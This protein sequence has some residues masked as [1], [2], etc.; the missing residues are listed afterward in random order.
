[1]LLLP[2]SD[3]AKVT[4]KATLPPPG[5]PPDESVVLRSLP[6]LKSP[7]FWFVDVFRDDI[8]IGRRWAANRW[9]CTVSFTE[10]IEVNWPIRFRFKAQRGLT[11]Y[12]FRRPPP[13]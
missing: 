13:R 8:V 11:V 7:L 2:A 3:S 12:L 5:E 4:A 6:H 10:T 9:E 1:V